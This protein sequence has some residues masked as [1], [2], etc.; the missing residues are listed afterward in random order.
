[1]VPRNGSTIVWSF[2]YVYCVRIYDALKTDYYNWQGLCTSWCVMCTDRSGS[3]IQFSKGN[4][5]F[6]DMCDGSTSVHLVLFLSG[7]NDNALFRLLMK[8]GK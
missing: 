2:L 7:S 6:F 1:M 5:W 8:G 4:F 3:S